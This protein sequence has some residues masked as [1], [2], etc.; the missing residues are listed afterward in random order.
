LLKIQQQV[1]EDIQEVNQAMASRSRTP[2]EGM[3]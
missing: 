1:Q 2:P 3:S